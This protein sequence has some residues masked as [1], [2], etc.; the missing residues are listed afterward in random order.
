MKILL[1]GSTGY[2]GRRL[3]PVLVNAGHHVVC[4]VRD[5]R[6]FDWEDF[7][8]SFLSRIDVIEGDLADANSL[9]TIPSDI[10][11]AYYL[12]HSLGNSYSGF[13]GIE[14]Q[15][16]QNFADCLRNTKAQQI[17]YLGG[18]VNDTNL[19]EHL[20]SR[21]NVETILQSSG[22]P[23]TVLRAAIIIGSG[24]ASFEIIRDL[25]EKLPVMIAPKWLNSKCQPI[26][27]RNVIDYLVAVLGNKECFDK[28]YDI[29]GPDV[30]TYHEMLM[31]YARVRKLKRYILTLPVL[32]PRLSSLWLYFVTTTS[33]PLAR[34]LV[35]SMKNDVV[36]EMG[37][38]DSVVSIEKI[39]YVQA[40]EMAFSRI[41]QKNIVSSWIDAVGN[42]DIQSNFMDFIDVP[43]YGCLR[44][45]RKRSFPKQEKDRIA[46]NI[47]AIGGKRGWYFG[48]W[49]WKIR[50]F[51]DK[52][53]GGVGL[54]RGRRSPAELK[55]GDALDFWRVILADEHKNRL[56]LYA[57]M[58]LPGEAW[59]EFRI[60][61]HPD[62]MELIQT[63]TFRPLGLMGRLYWYILIP[64]HALIFPKMAKA[65]VN[66]IPNKES[67][68][69]L[70][71]EENAV[72]SH[73]Y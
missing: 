17:I 60:V 20:R 4:I 21:R 45:V 51:L 40:L 15:T 72:S 61:E 36:V 58:K 53:V 10:D 27:I 39:T 32:T 14:K 29:G 37:D 16:A 66:F 7:S 5:K 71:A 28:T 22:I 2:L 46:A 52:A 11:A 48:N 41:N 12:V 67:N 35:E 63:A 33:Y 23:T 6:R 30:L 59:L 38:I 13:E 25:V 55:A 42:R 50:G 56:L 70:S 64:F 19:S 26:G 18:I 57:E 62:T 69:N 3:L 24:S 43:K 8:E 31:Q 49:M 1:T 68:E 65:I 34:N 73:Q 9:K 54:R 44:D 47:W